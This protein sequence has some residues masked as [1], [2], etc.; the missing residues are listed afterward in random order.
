MSNFVLCRL[1]AFRLFSWWKDSRELSS[2][3]LKCGMGFRYIYIKKIYQ[4]SI[5]AA[6]WMLFKFQ[7][8]CFVVIFFSS[9]FVLNIR[10]LHIFVQVIVV[11]NSVNILLSEIIVKKLLFYELFIKDFSKYFIVSEYSWKTPNLWVIIYGFCI[12]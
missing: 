12:H 9:T 1:L 11:R 4:L 2:I 8:P 3:H 5:Q 6:Q 7:F 10:T